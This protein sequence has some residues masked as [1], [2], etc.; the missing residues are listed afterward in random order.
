MSERSE[1]RRSQ[2]SSLFAGSQSV[3]P[4]YPVI[5]ASFHHGKEG[6]VRGRDRARKGKEGDPS[7]AV[8]YPAKAD[9]G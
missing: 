7:S 4:F 9:S 8:R 5:F 6:V 2:R 3:L 1:F